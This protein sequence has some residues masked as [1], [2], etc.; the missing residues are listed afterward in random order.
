MV[1]NPYLSFN[2]N[3]EE[4]IN[5]YKGVFGGEITQLSRFGETSAPVPDDYKDN[6]MHIAY[7]FDDN[8]ILA[9]DLMPGSPF[10]I[11]NNFSLSVDVMQIMEMEKAFDKLAE[12][13][14]VTMPLQDTFWGARFGMLT[15]KF[16]VNWL[17]NCDLN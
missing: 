3:C 10:V 7:R 13:G 14:K 17:F 8:T 12:G 1:L 15:D 16:G 9:S 2:G 11:G 4:A 6:I 5:F